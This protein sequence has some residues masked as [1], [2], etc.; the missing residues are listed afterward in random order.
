M[1]EDARRWTW[2]KIT[3]AVLASLAIVGTLG[4]LLVGIVAAF[5]TPAPPGVSGPAPTA[6]R[7]PTSTAPAV[8]IAPL[9]VRPVVAVYGAT[10]E[11]CATPPPPEPPAE[12]MTCDI[13]QTGLFALEPTTLELQLTSVS[14]VTMPNRSAAV[15]IEMTQASQA[16]FAEY[17]RGHVGQQLAFMRNGI[18]VQAP[19]ITAP[20]DSRAL[21]FAGDLTAEQVGR[22]LVMLRD[23][24]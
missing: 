17:T 10:P 20:L 5:F 6:L 15:Q 22:M 19:N 4:T 21:Q 9:T 8:P 12:I 16:A 14:Q 13:D 7:T 11:L 2:R 3:V 24:R 23:D 1:P 18:V